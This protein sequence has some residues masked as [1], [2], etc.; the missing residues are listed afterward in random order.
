[1]A[2]DQNMH[3]IEPMLWGTT[4]PMFL[5]LDGAITEVWVRGVCTLTIIDPAKAEKNLSDIQSLNRIIRLLFTNAASEGLYT[6]SSTMQ[7]AKALANQNEALARSIM[8]QV[9]TN[10]NVLGLSIHNI[11]VETIEIL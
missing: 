3:T 11:I 6:L 2:A 4:S 1:M 5:M 8:E 10:I 7:D 9:E